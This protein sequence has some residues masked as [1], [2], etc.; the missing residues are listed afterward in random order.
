MR[1]GEVVKDQQGDE[2]RGPLGLLLRSCPVERTNERST[3]QILPNTPF[4]HVPHPARLFSFPLDP[5][6]PPISGT[7]A[8]QLQ[9]VNH[10]RSVPHQSLS[11]SVAF[12]PLI[13][14]C[15]IPPAYTRIEW[16]TVARVVRSPFFSLRHGHLGGTRGG[17]RY[18]A[19]C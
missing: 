14:I 5:F 19:L 16:M 4:S 10:L 18:S 12:I 8:L 17:G 3:Q 9:A 7:S 11:V 2:G 15:Q 1:D 13:T 6:F